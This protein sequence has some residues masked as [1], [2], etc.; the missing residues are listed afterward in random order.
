MTVTGDEPAQITRN[1]CDRRDH[2]VEVFS[3]ILSLA[4]PGRL[5]QLYEGDRTKLATSDQFHLD[6]DRK[7]YTLDHAREL[8]GP[9]AHKSILGLEIVHEERG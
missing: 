3:R 8:G 6:Q 4:L 7:H 1:Y 2:L 5:R 9:I